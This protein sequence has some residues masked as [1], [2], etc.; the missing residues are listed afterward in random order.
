MSA[1]DPAASAPPATR[2]RCPFCGALSETPRARCPA[3]GRI[4][5][6]PPGLRRPPRAD[7]QA[8]L[9]RIA[10]DA[11]RQR[12]HAGL[13]DMP[14]AK[15]RPRQ[16]ALVLGALLIILGVFFAPRP[17]PALTPARHL[18]I[19]ARGSVNALRQALDRFRAD[20][21]R[22]PS[23]AE[24]LKALVINPP[25]PGWNGPYVNLV[26]P[27]PWHTPFI[28]KLDGEC[29]IVV[30][31]GSD[32]RFGTADDIVPDPPAGVGEEPLPQP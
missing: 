5:V 9:Q 13:D 3:C 7:R 12:R 30:S 4:R 2:L 22:Y 20:C 28:Y 14:L 18:D 1:S 11:A 23:V 15:R 8:A 27:D 6:L 26:R 21:G 31:A 24:G 25:L 16:L 32:R 17:P 29:P 19:R 10:R